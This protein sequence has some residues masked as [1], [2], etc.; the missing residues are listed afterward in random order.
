[1]TNLDFH[2]QTPLESGSQW[3]G[4]QLGQF[5]LQK[6]IG[7]GGMG[8]VFRALDTTLNR[9]VAV[10][11]LSRDQSA[12]DET[13]RR[14]RNEAQSAARLNHDNIARVFYVGE[15]RGVHYIVFEF[16][17]GVNIRDLVEQHGP[18]PLEAA[19]SY[20]YQIARALEH[21]SHRAVIHRDIKPSN[22][23]ISPDGTAKLVDMGLARLNQLAPSGD[24]L[25][26]SGVTL[27]TFDY[28]SP[29]QAR[30]PRSAD[31]RSDLYSLGCSFFFM[32]TGRPPFPDG[33]VLQKLLQHQADSPPDPR[34]FRPELPA[35][36]TH[37]LARLLAKN[38]AGRYQLP[39]GLIDELTALGE[40]LG[41]QLEVTR[42][43]W[44]APRRSHPLAQWQ[45]HLAWIV[46][47]AALFLIVLS[48]DFYWSARS[49][50]ATGATLLT[51]GD[52]RPATQSMPTAPV[53]INAP[54]APSNDL[55]PLEPAPLVPPPESIPIGNDPQGPSAAP[56][57]ESPSRGKTLPGQPL[58]FL[59]DLL[60]ELA[61]AR[62]RSGPVSPPGA[63]PNDGSKDDLDLSTDNVPVAQPTTPS[64]GAVAPR[65]NV[66][67]VGDESRPGNY[68]SLHAACSQAK[69]GDVVE[70]RYDGRRIERRPIEISNVKLS[71]RAAEG[72]QPIV[73]YQPESDWNSK[74]R[75]VMISVAGGQLSASGIHW[76]FQL[77]KNDPADWVFFETRRCDLLEF[78]RCTLTTRGQT[79]YQGR[80]ALIDIKAPPGPHA[81]AMDPGAVDAHVVV[82]RLEN[83]VARGEA[84]LLR[85]N[86]LQAVRLNWN[87]GLLATS[88]RLFVAEGNSLQP[89]RD[90]RAELTLRHVTAMVAG[91][92]VLLTNSQEA[93]YQVSTQITCDDCIIASA[94]KA[95]LVEQRG[96]DSIDQYLTRF[97][98]HGQRNF[99]DGFDV[100]WRIM[101]STGQ[102]GSK[103]LDF[104][105]WN[106]LWRGQSGPQTAGRNAVVWRGL[107]GEDRPAHDHAPADYA[108]DPSAPVNAARRGGSDQSDAGCRAVDLPAPPVEVQP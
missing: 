18:L 66:L 24:D 29:E 33:T 8:I 90:V 37:I 86:D 40:S 94:G 7:G 9:E 21:A 81:M 96:S 104:D 32:L 64:P 102:T 54:P 19:V 70:L 87:N 51:P 17:E 45:H 38:P 27:G 93:P 74:Y 53:P 6:F 30:D 91:G 80:A 85:D 41:M 43:G 23:L 67:T 103:Q 76:E 63:P 100:F 99:F 39:A 71:I 79:S 60:K 10:K 12:D 59:S 98:W 89:H 48:L 77:P 28:I 55:E 34:N 46:P 84:A 65:V 4:E 56:A 35:E 20:T 5:Q 13:L 42:G 16:I 58:D 82:V 78:D 1:V 50:D 73:V 106:E 75:P 62:A 11:V 88:A 52:Q 49:V 61:A 36:V 2:D 25:T 44:V 3:E 95:P 101:N 108:L 107:P 92:L 105:Q 83:C 14:F 31:V 69:D 15:D 97:E 57:V 72:F 26:A 68:A 47:L 22:V